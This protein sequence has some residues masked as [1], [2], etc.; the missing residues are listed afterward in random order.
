MHSLLAAYQ[1][2][3]ALVKGS[4]HVHAIATVSNVWVDSEVPEYLELTLNIRTETPTVWKIR[5]R[6]ESSQEPSPKVQYA[7]T[8]ELFSKIGP[9]LTYWSTICN[10]PSYLRVPPLRSSTSQV[11]SM[12]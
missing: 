9:L 11:A 3:S 10:R 8:G 2:M 1:S 5:A 4:L 12:L 7:V 6:Y